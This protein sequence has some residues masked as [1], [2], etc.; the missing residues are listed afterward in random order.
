MKAVVLS[1]S[2][3]L[4]LREVKDPSPGP[5]EVVLAVGGCGICG[6]D[7]HWVA[8]GRGPEGHILGHEFWGEVVEV[9]P[10]VTRWRRGDWV[11]V[12]P[13]GSCGRCAA[14]ARGMP[15]A[16]RHRPNLGI[17]AAGAFAEYVAVPEDQLYRV[18]AGVDPQYASCAEPLAVALKALEL[19]GGVAGKDVLVYGVGPIGLNVVLAARHQGARKIVAVGRAESRR[20]AAREC[21]ADEVVNA[22]RAD[23][24][25]LLQQAGYQFDAVFECSGAA[26]AVR[27][28]VLALQFGGALVQVGL[29]WEALPVTMTDMVAKGIRWI[30]SC[31]FDAQT[32]AEAHRW[33]CEGAVNPGLFIREQ[34]PLEQVPDAFERLASRNPPVKIQVNP[35]LRA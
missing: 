8:A 13:I 35:R 30:G 15:F 6:S 32:F 33:I 12:N 7:V 1:G 2:G 25:S 23:V 19:A 10:G 29:G 3:G 11:A 17:S 31:A 20:L 24:P 16:C 26:Q 34:V 9:G 4:E 22:A 18:P 28:G 14:C 27:A 21:G 5:G